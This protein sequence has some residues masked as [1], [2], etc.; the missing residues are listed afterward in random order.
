MATAPPRTVCGTSFL[1]GVG[2]DGEEDEIEPAGFGAF[3]RRLL[4]DLALCPPY[5]MARPAERAEAKARTSSN[6]RSA[7][8][9]SVTVPTAPVA[10][11]TPMR[12]SGIAAARPL[13][14]EV[15]DLVE[16]SHGPLD[17]CLRHRTRF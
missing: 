4:D 11:T 2:A 10:P 16:G 13:G 8:S 1:A 17:G 5:G 3:R 14:A 15:E 9:S 6:P 12:T 7:S